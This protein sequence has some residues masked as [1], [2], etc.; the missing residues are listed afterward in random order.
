DLGGTNMRAAAVDA[1][2]AIL[3]RAVAPTPRRAAT[4]DPFLTF[5]EDFAARHDVEHA[6]VA[7]PGRV[8]HQRGLLLHAPNLPDG[9]A[10]LLTRATLEGALGRPVAL[11]NDADVAAVGEA[12]FGAGRG[13]GDIVYLTISTGV[14]AGIL[15]GGRLLLPRYSGG[16]VGHSVVE[17]AL[18]A[19]GEDGTVEGLGSGTAINRAARAAGLDAVGP[20]IVRL[21]Q[22]GDPVAAQVWDDAMFAVA[23]GVVNLAHLVAPTVVVI[24]GGVGRNG[25]LVHAP[26]RA[27]LEHLGPAGPRAEVV[28]AELG[29][30]SGLIGAAAW[31]T[32]T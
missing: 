17:G 32:A 11:A 9:W 2:G 26:I 8:D 23:L 15:V 28:G 10:P 14:G 20:D 18:A 1:T 13:H 30:D 5:V 12:R 22:A 31:R 21:V 19:A 25:E 16:E 3:E 27:A 29:D 4:L 24:G 7:L 6:V